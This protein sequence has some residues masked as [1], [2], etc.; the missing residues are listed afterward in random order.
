MS[1]QYKEIINGARQDWISEF[2]KET[3]K[4][5]AMSGNSM[6]FPLLVA[7]AGLLV[8]PEI[9]VWWIVIAFNVLAIIFFCV[10]TLRRRKELEKSFD[11]NFATD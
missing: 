9:W 2:R 3:W 5:V 8:F 11:R 1:G 7:I 4:A 10:S 6:I